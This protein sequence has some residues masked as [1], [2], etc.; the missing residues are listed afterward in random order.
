[1]SALT[2]L[3]R[4]F[5]SFGWKE[6]TWYCSTYSRRLTGTVAV[7]LPVAVAVNLKSIHRTH[8]LQLGL[9]IQLECCDVK[10]EA[11]CTT[12]IDP[13]TSEPKVAVRSGTDWHREVVRTSVIH[14]SV[15]VSVQRGESCAIQA[16]CGSTRRSST[17]R[18]DKNNNNN[19]ISSSS[20]YRAERESTES[21]QSLPSRAQLAGLLQDGPPRRQ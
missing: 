4:E 10:A 13:S 8:V 14:L 5:N 17:K 7:A 15:S 18:C 21:F 20:N 3:E 19:S 16:G 2:N 9:A 12:A 1:M 11:A 6:K